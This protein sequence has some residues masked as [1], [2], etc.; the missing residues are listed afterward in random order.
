MFLTNCCKTFEPLGTVALGG[1]PKD[2]SHDPLFIL[3][4]PCIFRS[5]DVC[6]PLFV[7]VSLL[8]D[9]C[10][11]KSLESFFGFFIHLIGRFLFDFVTMRGFRR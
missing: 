6:C 9:A 7:G 1:L 4:L 10:K 11:V 2:F 8:S 5:R 3:A